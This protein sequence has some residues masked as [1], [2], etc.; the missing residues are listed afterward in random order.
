MTRKI[1]SFDYGL[2]TGKDYQIK[3]QDD[4]IWEDFKDIKTYINKLH[5]QIESLILE[6]EELQLNKKTS[7]IQKV[8]IVDFPVD[9]FFETAM[10]YQPQQK[11]PLRDVKYD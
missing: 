4:A 10:K 7:K 11:K 9:K 5:E 3:S 8:S 2:H 1:S 6:V